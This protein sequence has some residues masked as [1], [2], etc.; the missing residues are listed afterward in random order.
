MTRTVWWKAAVGV[1]LLPLVCGC[2]AS[3]NFY[4]GRTLEEN[5]LAIGVAAD[6]I[7]VK[8]SSGDITVS[9]DKPFAP[10]ILGAYGL[11]LRLELGARWYPVSFFELTLRHQV[12]PRTFDIIDGSLNLHF[13]HLLGAYSYLK[14]GVTISKNL[15]G[16]EPYL[17]YS[18]YHYLGAT[19]GIF[20]D[21]FIS[22]LGEVFIDNNR[23]LGFGIA[24]PVRKA[25]LIPEANYQYFGGDFSHGLWHVGI[26]LRVFTNQDSPQ[27]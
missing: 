8:S 24:L 16:V 11:P 22:G 26:G 12:N 27:E 1:S 21:S 15:H 17:H 14:Y 23:V 20:D 4:T 18:A 13:A 25:Q 6:D 19:S 10:V 2:V 9:K 5:K 3:S 7:Y